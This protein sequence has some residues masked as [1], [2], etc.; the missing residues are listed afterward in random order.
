M[1]PRF[2]ELVAKLLPSMPRTIVF[3]TSLFVPDDVNSPTTVNMEPRCRLRL[4]HVYCSY[5]HGRA[6]HRPG[7]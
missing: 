3:I 6:S 1:V 2:S 5:F 7:R 4:S